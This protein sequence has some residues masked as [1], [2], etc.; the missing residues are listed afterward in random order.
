MLCNREA[1]EE[2]QIQFIHPASFQQVAS[3]IGVGAGLGKDESGVRILRYVAYDIACRSR[4][5]SHHLPVAQKP[6][7]VCAS[8]TVACG[9]ENRSITGV[10]EITVSIVEAQSVNQLTALCLI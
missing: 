1:L 7:D 8:V 4:A 2:S 10:I 5:S 9:I 6:I 3:G